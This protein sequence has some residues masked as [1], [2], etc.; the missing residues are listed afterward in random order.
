MSPDIFVESIPGLHQRL[1]QVETAILET[2]GLPVKVT[3]VEATSH[4]G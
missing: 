2:V 1:S 4:N 3:F